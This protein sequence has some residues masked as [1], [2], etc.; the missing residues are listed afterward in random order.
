F[1]R[2]VLVHV[3]APRDPVLS[4]DC[5]EHPQIPCRAL[6]L[7]EV[8]SRQQIT[9]R[10]VHGTHQAKRR[11]ALLE[12]C[13]RAPV[14]QEHQPGLGFALPPSPVPPCTSSPHCR[15]AGSPQ[16]AAHR[17]HRQLHHHPFFPR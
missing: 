10:V 15:D 1:Q 4:H 9:R 11:P 5:L 2:P 14:P 8:S 13:V 12:P 6:L 16:N 17:P 3:D 7:H